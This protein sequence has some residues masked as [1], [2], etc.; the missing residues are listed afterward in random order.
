MTTSATPSPSLRLS[1]R[2]R[3]I[4]AERVL[5]GSYPPGTQLKDT[6]LADEF[7]TSR[8]PVREALYALEMIGLVRSQPSLGT[9]RCGVD[10]ARLTDA[11]ELRATL[12]ER[13]AQLAVPCLAEDL[14]TLSHALAD[15]ERAA[16]AQDAQAYSRAI[17]RFHRHI[18]MMSGNR[19]FLRVWDFQH[20]ELRTRVAAQR[21]SHELV[22]FIG[23]HQAALK[24]LTV[25]DG[26][27]AG[28][29]L[30]GL[31][32]RFLRVHNALQTP[33]SADH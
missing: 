21:V 6:T 13:A 2:L 24:A 18:I 16:A 27:G 3:G 25:G 8:T 31:I 33:P 26:I 28:Q 30:R 23:G 15:L 14:L 7:N 17:Q 22:D 11:Y 5:E 9:W 10:P 32:E 29:Q 20:W 4:I 19:E 12:E 1:D